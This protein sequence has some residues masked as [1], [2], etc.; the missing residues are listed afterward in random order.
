MAVNAAR[1]CV[2]SQTE[3]LTSAQLHC[4]DMGPESP[5]TCSRE[6]AASTCALTAAVSLRNASIAPLDAR[7]VACH[8]RPVRL[9][10]CD[11]HEQL[12]WGSGASYC[13][14]A[15]KHCRGVMLGRGGERE[16]R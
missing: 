12:I 7:L 8:H 14:W 2:T 3:V 15:A 4:Q 16:G 13:I 6:S 9:V 1:T 10:A 5:H 11:I